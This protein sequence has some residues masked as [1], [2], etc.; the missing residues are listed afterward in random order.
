MTPAVSVVICTVDR[1][2]ALRRALA[3]LGQ[4]TAPR[5]TFEVIVVDN[6][7]TG[8]T[9]AV[10]AEAAAVAPVRQVREPRQGLSFARNCGVQ[11]SRGDLI[12]FTDD[13]VCVAPDW[14]ETIC[15]VAAERR[16]AAWFGGRV[17]PVWPSP[18]PEWLD[19][20]CW[21][22]LALLDFG[23]SRIALGGVEPRS[24]IGANLIRQARRVR[25]GGTVRAAG[26]ARARRHRVDRGSRAADQ[27]GP[28]WTARTVRALARGPQPG[29]S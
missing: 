13:D 26:A 1:A 23:S 27:I 12:A 14:I 7:A 24:A 4:Q 25:G 11:A 20:S 22:P 8:E 5:S 17:L 21:A 9:V 16:D 19:A 28:T 15:G 2:D 29:Q 3:A 10:M 18:A 6:N